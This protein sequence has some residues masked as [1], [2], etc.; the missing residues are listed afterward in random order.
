MPDSTLTLLAQGYAWLPDRFRR[1]GGAPVRT[2]LL[3]KPAVAL[4]GPEAVAFFYD[5][6]HVRRRSALPEPVID[7]L[8]GQG[9]VHTLDGAVHRAR[10]A[11]FTSLLKDGGRVTSL[12]EEVGRKWSAA[13]AEWKGGAPVVLFD[14]VGLLLTKAV[15]AWA[16]VP[17][18]PH[19]ATAV[20]RD[21]LAMVDGFATAGP[22]HLRARRARARQEEH[23]AREI[24]K[25]RASGAPE[26]DGGA[27]VAYA[28]AVH[29]D[30]DGRLL[31]A[32][33]AAVELLNV[34]RPTVAVTWYT[35]F[36]AHALHRWPRLRAFLAEG[37]PAEARAFGH[38][39]RRFYPFAP[40]VG[41]LAA[42]DLEWQGT[43]I[44][45]GALVLLDLHGQNHDPAL[46]PR[47]YSFEPERFLGHE[48][49]RDELVPQGGGDVGAGHRCPGE[50]VTLAVL[51][52]LTPALAGLEYTVPDQDLRIPLSRVPTAPRSGF[53]LAVPG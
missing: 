14:E 43:P 38:E 42:R 39:V 30:A 8:F 48:P 41:G 17:R 29:R 22:R 44:A 26:A 33:T 1:T 27:S 28:I 46:W 36:A 4:H 6:D 12:A 40:F 47:P 25:L 50:D 11:M 24:M 3:G 53:R 10:K 32:R 19:E 35:V 49:G 34:L 51:A 45:E 21:L 23:F 18:Q 7:T 16:G 13:T 2:R 52:T 15:C 37:G 5:E 9:A 20:A 31:D